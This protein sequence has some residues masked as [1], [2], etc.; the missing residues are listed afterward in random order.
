MKKILLITDM[1]GTLLPSN[2]I[3]NPIDKIAVDRFL[4]DGNMF[5]IATGR[6][7]PS[8]AQYFDKISINGPVVLF[9]G[10]LIYD[11]KKDISVMKKFLS[12]KAFDIVTDIFAN[13]SEIGGE[14]DLMDFTHVPKLNKSEEFHIKRSYKDDEYAQTA[15]SDIPRGE[16]MK[17]LFADEPEKITELKKYIDTKNYTEVDFIPS[18]KTYFEMLPKGVSKGAALKWIIN[19]YKLHNYL[20]VACGDYDNDLSMLKTAD[21]AICPANALECVKEVAHYVAKASCNDGFIAEAID[22]VLNKYKD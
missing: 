18:S 21:I 2:K 15:L 3:I 22:F 5:S 12:D 4:L 17:V 11:I 8:A 6:S 16:W 14:I 9:N 10:G 13:F 7:L 19:E 20:I 1:D